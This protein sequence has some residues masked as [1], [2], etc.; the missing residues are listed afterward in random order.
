[1]S[2]Y[3]SAISPESLVMKTPASPHFIPVDL[4]PYFNASRRDLARGGV[5]PG[6]AR[7]D[8]DNEWSMKLRGA[9]TLRGM[10]FLFGDEDARD[11]LV[12]RPDEG[13]AD[14]A[15]APGPASYVIFVQAVVDRPEHAPDGFG[16]LGP[17]RAV[18]GNELGDLVST[19]S[20]RYI[21]GSEA[22]VPVLRR[23]GIQQKHVSWGAHPFA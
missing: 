18:R 6:F 7:Q 17:V 21:D 16:Q 13:P 9:Q 23:F 12:L 14:I 15:F 20:L 10:P 4:K 11:V 5:T 3:I 8:G 1:R 19:Y 2:S 22:D